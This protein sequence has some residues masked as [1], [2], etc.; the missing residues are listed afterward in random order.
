M[1]FPGRTA[2]NADLRRNATRTRWDLAVGQA[3]TGLVSVQDS[4]LS[5]AVLALVLTLTPGLD[6]A[7]VLRT[8]AREGRQ[9]GVAA[10]LGIT[11][12]VLLGLIH[13]LEALVWFLVLIALVDRMGAVLRRPIVQ[14]GI[15]AVAGTII[16][17]FGVALALAH[18]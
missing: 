8:A 15:D 16:M 18:S 1:C 7:L 14:R 9:A 11:T 3:H 2:K 17:G 13:N 10:A 5:F 12:G 4:L 6:T